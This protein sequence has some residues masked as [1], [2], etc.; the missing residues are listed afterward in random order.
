M[1]NLNAEF[2]PACHELKLYKERYTQK[3]KEMLKLEKAL[4]ACQIKLQQKNT[5]NLNKKHKAERGQ[6]QYT[7]N[8]EGAA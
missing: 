3:E 4:T 1:A 7:T 6:H 2:D 5:R 8:R